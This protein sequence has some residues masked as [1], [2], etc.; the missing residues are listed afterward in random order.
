[1]EHGYEVGI[2]YIRCIR[3]P[4]AAAATITQ[5]KQAVDGDVRTHTHTVMGKCV[6]VCSCV[7][8]ARVR[9]VVFGT[10]IYIYIYCT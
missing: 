3:S 5:S 8:V 9:I 6:R 1:M 4:E 7:Y 2:R 10:R